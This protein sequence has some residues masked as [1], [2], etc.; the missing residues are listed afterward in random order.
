MN[1]KARL[2]AFIQGS[3][4]AEKARQNLTY[5][6]VSE[7]L[8]RHGIRQSATNLSTKVGRGDMSAQ[9]FLALMNVLGHPVIDVR[10]VLGEPVAATRDRLKTVKRHKSPG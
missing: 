8:R 4:R 6:E 2:R 9:L 3:V 5:G 7:R 10:G 1:D